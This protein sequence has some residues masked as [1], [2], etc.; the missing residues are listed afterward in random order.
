MDQYL[1][2]QLFSAEAHKRV[3]AFVA[4][5]REFAIAVEQ[6]LNEKSE[7]LLTPQIMIELTDVLTLHYQAYVQ[8]LLFPPSEVTGIKIQ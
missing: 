6:D 2:H 5:L 3:R 4:D 7:T 1:E 8:T